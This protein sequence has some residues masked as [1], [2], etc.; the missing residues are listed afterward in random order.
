MAI[1]QALWHSGITLLVVT[2]EPDVA[3]FASRVLVMRDGRVISDRAQ[4]A[5]LAVAPPQERI[6]AT[7]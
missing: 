2:H 6:G 7:A 4:E 5:R 3:A 1:F